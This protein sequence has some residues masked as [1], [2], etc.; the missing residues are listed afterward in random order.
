MSYSE[1]PCFNY[2]ITSYHCLCSWGSALLHLRGRDC[3]T[4]TIC[5][6]A[7]TSSRLP[8]TLHSAMW[9]WQPE[10]NCSGSVRATEIG[11][12]YKSERTCTHTLVFNHRI[13]ENKS[14]EGRRRWEGERGRISLGKAR[15][16]QWQARSRG[17]SAYE[18][19]KQR[20]RI[21]EDLSGRYEAPQVLENNAAIVL[22]KGRLTSTP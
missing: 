1:L 3:I 22:T 6:S 4:M 9:H 20:A 15:V 12:C 16:C 10:V 5:C 11:K 8:P 13:I 19:K 17:V 21:R 7:F 18:V 14:A 2:F